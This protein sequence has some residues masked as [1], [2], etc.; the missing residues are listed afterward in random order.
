M[1]QST[2]TTLN[3]CNWNVVVYKGQRQSHLIPNMKWGG[4][5]IKDGT[6]KRF[7]CR[8]RYKKKKTPLTIS[9]SW[10]IFLYWITINQD[11]HEIITQMTWKSCPARWRTV[12]YWFPD[13]F[14][15]AEACRHG[16]RHGLHFVSPTKTSWNQICVNNVD[17]RL[18]NDREMRLPPF[19]LSLSR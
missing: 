17:S 6:I 18:R 16:W 14:Q 8:M 7:Y 9:W 13:F 3:W 12:L 1:Y 5:V 10:L 11:N 19:I 15:I 4:T 2:V